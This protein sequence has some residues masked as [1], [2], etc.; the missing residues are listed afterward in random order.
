[1]KN[2]I[3]SK[4]FNFNEMIKTE[5]G[6]ETLSFMF[7]ISIEKMIEIIERLDKEKSKG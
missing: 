4:T 6:V 7:N 2:G 3:D 5:E 1:M